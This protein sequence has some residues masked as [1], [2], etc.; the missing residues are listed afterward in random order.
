MNV[1]SHNH[2]CIQYPSGTIQP[3]SKNQRPTSEAFTYIH[4][5]LASCI[6]PS[7][8]LPNSNFIN[9]RSNPPAPFQTS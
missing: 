5:N 8:I 6:P 2:T 3:N 4:T 1:Q 7:S 9:K